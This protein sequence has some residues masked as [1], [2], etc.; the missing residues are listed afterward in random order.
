MATTMQD[1]A[2]KA[3]LSSPSPRSITSTVT[4]TIHTAIKVKFYY[5]LNKNLI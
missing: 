4:N 2:L 5:F 1:S 3:I